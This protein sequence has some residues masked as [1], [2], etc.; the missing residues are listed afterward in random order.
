[1]LNLI[2]AKHVLMLA[3]NVMEEPSNNVQDAMMDFYL[4]EV[5][6]N[7]DVSMEKLQLTENVLHA[8]KDVQYVHQLH[9]VQLV[10]LVNS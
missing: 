2:H 6:V 7:Q 3:L 8:Q 1:M 9:N 4:R 5:F 10:Y